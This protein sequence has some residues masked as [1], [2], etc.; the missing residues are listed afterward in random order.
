MRCDVGFVWFVSFETEEEALHALQFVRVQTFK[1]RP[2][3][4][5]IKS[6]TL[7]KSLY[8]SASFR[9]RMVAHTHVG[10]TLPWNPC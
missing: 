10:V 8:V 9:V 1:D 5:R 3:H 7:L 4:A 6:E 2:I